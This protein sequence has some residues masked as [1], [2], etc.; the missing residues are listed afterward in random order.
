MSCSEWETRIALHIEGDAVDAAVDRH[1]GECAACRRFAAGLR[2][3]Q[4]AL[5]DL[6]VEALDPAAL[7]AVRARVLAELDRPKKSAWAWVWSM[8]GAAA[9]LLLLTVVTVQVP[10]PVTLVRPPAAPRAPQAIDPQPAPRP[11]AV[12]HMRKRVRQPDRP[13]I[14]VL[15]RTEP[16]VVKFVTDDPNIVVIWLVEGKGETE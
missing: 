8:A 7:A 14:A 16:M 12:R 15:P 11:R 4:A 1:L 3:S 2:E 9:L 5:E 10:G 6:A 13:K